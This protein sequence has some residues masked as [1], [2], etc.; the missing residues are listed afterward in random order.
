[1]SARARNDDSM[2]IGEPSSALSEA[3][4]NSGDG[5][6]PAAFTLACQLAFTVFAHA[7]SH[8]VPARDGHSAPP[9]YAAILFTLLAVLAKS[10]A[11][12]VLLERAPSH[13]L[14]CEDGS[15]ERLARC[16][17]LPEDWCLRGLAEEGVS[18]KM[19]VLD[20]REG[21][22]LETDKERVEEEGSEEEEEL[23]IRRLVPGFEWRG[24]KEWAIDGVL[25]EKVVAWTEK[26]GR[27]REE[28]EARRSR[29]RG[30]DPMEVD[31]DDVIEEDS[32]DDES[33]PKEV[34][35]LKARQ[36]YLRPLLRP[37]AALSQSS[38]RRHT[39][40]KVPTLRRSPGCT[41]LVLDMDVFLATQERVRALI[42]SQQWAVIVPL[43]VI[44]ELDGLASSS[45]NSA[46]PFSSKSQD[47]LP[48]VLDFVRTVAHY[49]VFVY[50]NLTTCWSGRI[51]SNFVPILR[52]LSLYKPHR[53]AR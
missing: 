47:L 46:D 26:E 37:A 48:I 2:N 15:S 34:R 49:D 50:L 52:M 28:E 39:R 45:H 36:R 14:K 44:M 31:E 9:A 12:H 7:V 42:E 17:A 3:S 43:P 6:L 22:E 18:R 21:A 24:G 8:P 33:A 29:V 23:G 51:L 30:A 27:E 20:E 32:E 40:H 41:T 1:M 11:A 53:T 38:P 10:E 25:R 13:T 4:I 19:E 5:E 16:G 35:A